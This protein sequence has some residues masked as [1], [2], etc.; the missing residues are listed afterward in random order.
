MLAFKL[1]NLVSNRCTTGS[2]SVKRGHHIFSNA[3]SRPRA[4]VPTH[5]FPS[6]IGYSERSCCCLLTGCGSSVGDGR[7]GVLHTAGD[8]LVVS[9]ATIG[10]LPGVSTAGT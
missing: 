3:C 5:R 9:V 2:S 7:R 4:A 8:V 1:L 10:H 6:A